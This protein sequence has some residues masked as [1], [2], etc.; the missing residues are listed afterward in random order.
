MM[1]N[2]IAIYLCCGLLAGIHRLV[3]EIKTPTD[4]RQEMNPLLFFIFIILLWPVYVVVRL[5]KSYKKSLNV[6]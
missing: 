2:Y 4:L 1:N 3:R 5:I 6:P